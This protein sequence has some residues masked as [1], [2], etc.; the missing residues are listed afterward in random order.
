MATA[1]AQRPHTPPPSPIRICGG[2]GVCEGDPPARCARHTKV[3]LRFTIRRYS[4]L[5]RSRVDYGFGLG[6]IEVTASSKFKGE[7]SLELAC[8]HLEQKFNGDIRL[9]CVEFY[10]RGRPRDEVED[11]GNELTAASMHAGLLQGDRNTLPSSNRWGSCLE[12]AARV[13]GGF[14]ISD[15]LGQAMSHGLRTWKDGD[16]GPNGEDEQDDFRRRVQGKSWRCRCVAQDRSK[17]IAISDLLWNCVPIDY[18][19]RKIQHTDHIG[20]SLLSVVDPKENPFRQC[21]SHFVA[22]LTFEDALDDLEVLLDHYDFPEQGLGWKEKRDKHLQSYE[23]QVLHMCAHL[24]WRLE[25]LFETWPF[26]LLILV[27]ILED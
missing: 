11:I 7:D 4:D 3:V 24:W 8:D 14:M 17:K 19:W 10:L 15:I 25:L 18:L 5:L 20:S 12:A 13:G 26:L 16:P 1:I 23:D 6:T 27:S 22:L 21:H 9:A 2:A